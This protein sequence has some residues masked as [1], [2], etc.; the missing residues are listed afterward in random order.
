M[1]I[2]SVGTS[3][4]ASASVAGLVFQRPLVGLLSISV[5]AQP[6]RGTNSS[7][8][9]VILKREGETIVLPSS[10]SSCFALQQQCR[11]LGERQHKE[12][13]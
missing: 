1:H 8:M 7:P 13:L 5:V 4:V 2:N 11:C 9:T 6:Q 3:G 12:T 10:R